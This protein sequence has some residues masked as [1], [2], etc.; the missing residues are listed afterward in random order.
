MIKK[1][2]VYIPLLVYLKIPFFTK[3][4]FAI[5]ESKWS[6]PAAL[7]IP[8]YFFTEYNAYIVTIVMIPEI[9]Y[10]RKGSR[11]KVFLF[12]AA[13]IIIKIIRPKKRMKNPTV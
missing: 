13:N 7:F 1:A 8:K 9:E 4:N 5:L 6:N 10:P 2:Y 11:L 3:G 12:D